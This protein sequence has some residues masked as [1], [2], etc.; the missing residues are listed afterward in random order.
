MWHGLRDRK[1]GARV[2]FF[3]TR[4]LIWIKAGRGSFLSCTSGG[5]KCNAQRQRE[6]DREPWSTGGSSNRNAQD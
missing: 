5:I 6:G 4:D 1:K 3:G 2:G